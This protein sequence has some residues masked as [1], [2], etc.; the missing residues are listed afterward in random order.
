MIVKAFFDDD[1]YEFL[2]IPLWDLN[3]IEKY[4]DDFFSWMF[5]KNNDHKYWVA[6][7]EHKIGCDYGIEAFIDWIKIYH[8]V[9]IRRIQP[10][11]DFKNIPTL[12][13]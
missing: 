12:F 7:N 6:F 11:D 2:D 9:D 5:D 8:N 10:P 13:F 1:D 4:Q 3:D